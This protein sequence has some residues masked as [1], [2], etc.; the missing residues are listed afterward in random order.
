V[1]AGRA[2]GPAGRP[3]VGLHRQCHGQGRAGG[4]GWMETSERGPPRA[5][6]RLINGSVNR[7]G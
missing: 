4:T 7:N 2:G 5:P 3:L 1:G 6:Q